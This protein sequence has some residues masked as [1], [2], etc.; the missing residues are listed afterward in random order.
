MKYIV[1]GLGNYG[2]VLAK[3]LTE[4]GHEVIGVDREMS[5]VESMKDDIAT[6]FVLDVTDEQ[7]LSIL[8]LTS[9]DAVIVAIGEAFGV[10][11]KCVALLKKRKVE[12][13]YANALDSLHKAVL[14]A[15]NIDMIITPEK[16]AARSLVQRLD[17]SVGVESLRI[18]KEYHVLKFKAP[19]S[20][21]GYRIADL[22]LDRE[23]NLKIISLLRGERVI[24]SLGIS[25]CDSTVEQS[26]D[27]EY[28]LTES[29][30]LV[31]YGK[32]KDFVLFWKSI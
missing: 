30:S 4:L 9:V 32:Y 12:H 26:I 20:I 6:S 2:R 11:I 5:K 1:I 14:E 15:F 13:I 7:A 25:V 21:V 24:N 22:A 29:D 3:E 10:S 28:K 8:P 18:D 17:L 19:K 27:P 16:D 23:F 31:C